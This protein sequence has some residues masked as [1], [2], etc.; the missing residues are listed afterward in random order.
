MA[1]EHINEPFSLAPVLFG[2][3]RHQ[4]RTDRRGVGQVLEGEVQTSRKVRGWSVGRAGSKNE[5]VKGK[6]TIEHCV[7]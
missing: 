2:R 7:S 4:A 6:I 3:G 1:F 5:D